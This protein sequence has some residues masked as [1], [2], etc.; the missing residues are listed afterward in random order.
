M[1]ISSS[2]VPG[3]QEE[4]VTL[5]IS[6]D[7]K[8]FTLNGTPTF[9]NGVSYY[10]AQSISSS[11]FRIMDLDD[12]VADG[13]NWIRVWVFWSYGNQDV[14]V[15]APN[16]A[17]RN[18]YMDRLKTLID[19]CN[20]RKII[21]DVSMTRGHHPFPENQAE[22][23]ACART[24]ANELKM[25]RNVYI[26]VSN[27][28]DVQDARHVPLNDV[29]GLITTIKAIDPDRLC[30]ASSVPTS[31]RDLS[32][33]ARV[34]RCDF[35]CPHL[36]RHQGSA[37]QTIQTVRE[38]IEWM[39]QQ[40]FR[41]PIHLQEPFRR[42]YA[43]Y[44]PV[45]DDF[46]RDCT[47]A[48]IAGAAGW[49]FHNGSDKVSQDK[50]P[51]RCFLMTDS[52]GRLYSQWDAVEQQVRMNLDAKLAGTDPA[53]LQ[54]HAKYPE[55]LAHQIGKEAGDAW[56]AEVARDAAGFLSYGPYCTLPA[57]DHRVVWRMKIDATTSPNDDVL[58]LDV[59]ANGDSFGEKRI[60]RQDFTAPGV[61]QEFSI[62]FTLADNRK[63]VEFRTYWPGKATIALSTIT[64]FVNKGVAT[65]RPPSVDAGQ[66]QVITLPVDT[67]TLDGAVRDDSLPDDAGAVK[68][69]WTK[70][71]GTGDVTFHNATA[72]STTATF[73]RA[74]AYVLRL[75]ADD[76][77]LTSYDEVTITV[78]EQG[79]GQLLKTYQ[80]AK[81]F[82]HQAG[83]SMGDVWRGDA[84]RHFSFLAFGPY[85][86][87][88]PAGPLTARFFLRVD[89]NT[90]DDGYV[91][92]LDIHDAN[93]GRILKNAI[94]TRKDWVK[95][96][97]FQIFDLQFVHTAGHSLEFRT[98]YMEVALLDLEKVEIWSM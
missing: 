14:S 81:D 26:D 73:S 95:P 71:Q 3:E 5:G 61:W 65:N 93:T 9:L 82:Q 37:T 70:Q 1:P 56:I 74:G 69:K 28:R 52:E 58:A 87:S 90:R 80:G 35:I 39:E 12:M 47:G 50:R 48:K 41:I 19:E 23:L 18:P 33:H 40:N 97:M 88:L 78:T 98:Y 31:A 2:A 11:S 89:N 34:G 66:D 15:I 57:G 85:D 92:I 62:D 36:P 7:G 44:N 54:Y 55:Q 21:V 53:V 25:Y 63:G 64:L 16:G 10:G 77:E 72:A 91:C 67:V 46:L 17:I 60:T 8:F 27:E 13:F 68:V 86:D 6:S 4:G 24:L 49:C 45:A 96:G 59:F 20:K 42:G 84:S 83:A 51:F 76:G 38:Y 29:G 32:D 30:T 75:T 94:L 22:H 79:S 43:G